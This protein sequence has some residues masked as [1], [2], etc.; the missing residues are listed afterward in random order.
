MK[1]MLAVVSVVLFSTFVALLSG[2]VNPMKTVNDADYSVTQTQQKLDRIQNRST[3]PSPAVVK[4]S[5]YYVN[6]TPISPSQGP[7]WMRNQIT[8]R[9]QNVPMSFLLSRILRDTDASVSYQN[10][11][12][13]NQLLSMDYSGDIKGAL[14]EIAA[15]TNYAYTVENNVVA[16]NSY[17]TKTFNISFMPGTSSYQVGQNKGLG[18]GEAAATSS[19]NG[20]NTISTVNG[21]LGEQ[22]YSNLTGSLSVWNDL[23]ATLNQLKSSDGTVSISESTTTVTVHDHPSNVLAMTDYI[24]QLN[25]DLSREVAIQVEV[26]EVDLDKEFNYGINWNTVWQIAGTQIGIAGDLAGAA[27]TPAIATQTLGTSG[28][29]TLR[30]GNPNASNALIQALS[31]QGRV[32]VVTQPRVVTM[33]N[34]MAEI[35]ITR[36]VAYLQSVSNTTTANAGNASNTQ[37]LTP[38]VVTD[39]F[40]LYLL[41]KI[42]KNRVYLQISSALSNLTAINTVSNNGTVNQPVPT[43]TATAG[44]T[45]VQQGTPFQAI[46]VPTL[47][48]KM[49]NQRTVVDSGSTLMI[50]GFQQVRDQTQRSQLFGIKPLGGTG[51]ERR[52]VQTIVLITP[53]V[54][55]KY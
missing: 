8:L 34:Q 42:Q 48:N 5:G 32:S 30:L 25:R 46:Q 29:A 52:N 2:C 21:D 12:N 38:G 10:G 53:T 36:D 44:T 28:I 3:T 13:Q 4:Y 54:L 6:P 15:D 55:G 31:Q 37:T 20:T 18:A 49:F 7:L 26:I 40:T 39:G 47:A 14:K 22:Q 43:A 33:N 1:K 19:G 45:T 23:S 16:W 50:T 27:A 24:N 9:A 17:L 41:P 35:K 51:A 11:A